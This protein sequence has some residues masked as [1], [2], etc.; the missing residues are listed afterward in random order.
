MLPPTKPESKFEGR[1][2]IEQFHKPYRT[3]QISG[4][5]YTEECRRTYASL[6]GANCYLNDH[7]S[8]GLECQLE[9][10]NKNKE[11]ILHW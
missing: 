1:N 6:E 4:D 9:K 8:E 11:A 10:Q 5:R 2:D 7:I 3:L